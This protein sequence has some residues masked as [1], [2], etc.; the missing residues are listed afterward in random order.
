MNM[1]REIFDNMAQVQLKHW[2]FLGRKKILNNII[3]GLKLEKNAKILEIGAGTGA[4]LDMLDKFGNLEATELDLKSREF[5]IS[6]GWT[7]FE[8]DLPDGVKNLDNNYDLICLIDVLEHIEL[9]EKLISELSNKI[10]FGGFLLISCPSYQWLYT[11]YDKKLGHFRRYNKIS[12]LRLFKDTS[13]N[14]K[15]VGFFNFLLFPL[16]ILGNFLERLGIYGREDAIKIPNSIL[17]NF[18][19]YFFIIESKIVRFFLFPFGASI[20]IVAK[21]N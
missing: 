21:K 18:F 19:L 4:N 14:I 6:N 7:V 16:I 8:C 15:R 13:L 11:D 5:C 1:D 17:N 2:W 12:I 9:D 20:L 10:S 3:L